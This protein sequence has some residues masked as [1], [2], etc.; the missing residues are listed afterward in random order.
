VPVKIT[1]VQVEN[2]KRVKAVH[3]EPSPNGLTIIGG[4]NRNGKTSVLDAIAWA[5]GGAKFAPTNP[6]RDDAIGNPAIALTLSNGLKVERKGKASA[7]TVIDPTGG[8]GGQ[9]LLD[10]FVSQFALDLPKFM[11]S[12]DRDKAQTLLKMLGIGEELARL[13]A[14]E[15]RIYNERHAIG[16][17]ADAKK[18]HAAELPEYGDAPA[19][20][21]S[22][23]ELIQSQQA[24]LAKN[25]ENQRKRAEV[26]IIAQRAENEQQRIRGLEE[27]LEEARAKYQQTCKALEIA[28]K[29]AADLQ[30]EST[31]AIE[32]SI[33]N[34]EAVNAQVAAN[35]TKARAT[36]EAETYRAQYDAKT[37]ELEDVRKR[38]LALL[39]NANL[40][41]PGLAVEHGELRY[42]GQPWDGMAASEQLR[43]ATAIVRRL[44][45]ECGF[46][47]M[48][49]LEQMDLD[50]LNEFGAWLESEGLQ[51]IATR[52]STGGECSIIIEDGLPQGETYAE[53]VTGVSDELTEARKDWGEF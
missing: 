47:L 38:R 43:V 8:R 24:I 11:N 20:P 34:I 23:S 3:L 26:T 17:I 35:Q 53:V 42:H 27:A 10:A 40:P 50:T 48:D 33:A 14:D 31:A 30:D 41:L 4:K 29:S 1:S 16:Q 12:N 44:N 2:V 52:V 49:K 9:Q 18:K 5:L 32:A 22:V 6:K 28:N 39:D 19:E 46:V 13:D 21:V 15:Q 36:D 25:G 7:L 37:E 51:V 45:P